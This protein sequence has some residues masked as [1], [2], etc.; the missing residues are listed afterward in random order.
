MLSTSILIA[1]ALRS[2][3]SHRRQI[4]TCTSTISA[5]SAPAYATY[6]STGPRAQYS[7]KHG[8]YNDAD[9]LEVMPSVRDSF[10]SDSAS[11]YDVSS[12]E[13][14]LKPGRNKGKP[15]RGAAIPD[16][17][18]VGFK[19]VSDLLRDAEA[20]RVKFEA[21]SGARR[22][23][24]LVIKHEVK[25]KDAS[26][27][28]TTR[29][30]KKPQQEKATPGT[31]VESGELTSRFFAT[32]A[33]DKTS[34]SKTRQDY[35]VKHDAISGTEPAAQPLKQNRTSAT[36]NPVPATSDGTAA[37]PRAMILKDEVKLRP[38]DTT[39]GEESVHRMQLD[40]GARQ[41]TRTGEGSETIELPSVGQSE[42]TQTSA[43]FATDFRDLIHS[44]S[45]TGQPLIP[46]NPSKLIK[47]IVPKP[48][49]REKVLPVKGPSPQ[50]SPLKRIALPTKRKQLTVTGKALEEFQPEQVPDSLALTEYFPVASSSKIAEPTDALVNTKQ[51]SKTTK[52]TKKTERKSLLLPP[53]DAIEILDK[54]KFV[55]STSSQLLIHSSSPVSES[56][57]TCKDTVS[58]VP[59]LTRDGSFIDLDS[60]LGSNGSLGLKSTRSL[61]SAATRN[62]DGSL[63]ISDVIDL[64][65]TPVR[66]SSKLDTKLPN[67]ILTLAPLEPQTEATNEVIRG[68]IMADMGT[69]A[70]GATTRVEKA[71]PALPRS[72]GEAST[73]QRPT[74]KSPVKKKR[75]TQSADTKPMRPEDG[76]KKVSFNNLK[77]E[78]KGFGIKPPRSRMRTIELILEHRAKKVEGP[79]VVTAAV[80]AI[81]PESLHIDD[82]ARSNEPLATNPSTVS[83]AIGPKVI[84]KRKTAKVL[85]SSQPKQKA[86]IATPADANTDD[87]PPPSFQTPVESLES[88]E[89]A[90]ELKIAALLSAMQ[91]AITSQLPT[92]SIKNP[93]WKEKIALYD[94]IVLEDLTTWLNT[95]GLDSV[96]VDAEVSSALVRDWC[97]S[98]SVCFIWVSEGWRKKR[99]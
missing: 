25:D 27:I 91:L 21:L 72:L 1:S 97:E 20:A 26:K 86:N 61:W 66:P 67:Q 52:R 2:A 40:T 95:G 75:K 5:L 31:V 42:D 16:G 36:T 28:K 90:D 79:A 78:L 98:K 83:G 70:K 47:A 99:S 38:Q 59:N 92:H 6:H 12:L 39:S 4:P 62:E 57:R 8:S 30:R 73:R 9:R 54:Q 89:E 84:I 22:S 41:Q 33:S 50:K 23:D 14:P 74:S 48:Q 24:E 93:S 51:K 64:S 3:I 37:S 80:M 96:G 45:Y 69:G 15:I 85:I 35:S 34:K 11:L 43:V 44:Y 58:I 77:E 17:I 68:R 88:N 87:L 32:E 7:A 65:E 82:E 18:T 53:S 76:F 13:E 55:F 94:T 56:I 19:K 10:D 60:F 49:R 81:E 29:A 71:I 46:G 63:M